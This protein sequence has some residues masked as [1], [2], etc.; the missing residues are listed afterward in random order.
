MCAADM[1]AEELAAASKPDNAHMKKQCIVFSRLIEGYM[2]LG[3]LG[4]IHEYHT[5]KELQLR[6]VAYETVDGIRVLSS[7]I[8]EI[9]C[10]G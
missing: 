1:V 5:P 2:Q 9:E 4:T 8:K 6:N 3:K 7:K 10:L